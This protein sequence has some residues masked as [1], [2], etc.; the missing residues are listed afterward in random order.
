LLPALFVVLLLSS[1]TKRT[2]ADILIRKTDPAKI[3]MY[4]IYEKNG[5]PFHRYSRLFLIHENLDYI[6]NGGMFSIDLD[7]KPLGLFIAE[8]VKWRPIKR[9]NSTKN[10]FGRQPQGVFLVTKEDYAKV[11]SVDDYM[12]LDEEQVRCATQSA[13]MLVLA[14]KVNPLLT[15]YKSTNMRNGVGIGAFGQVVF[16]C[17][18]EEV[19]LQRFAEMFLEQGCLS[20][21]NLDEGV[22]NLLER[23]YRHFE[24]EVKSGPFIGVKY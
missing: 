10:P 19:T 18:K 9:V 23:K 5:V 14:G 11:I 20:A 13:P 24:G 16:I 3:E 21:L 17:S 12:K 6:T 22:S 8:G 1:H 15:K 2:Y 7:C 4:W